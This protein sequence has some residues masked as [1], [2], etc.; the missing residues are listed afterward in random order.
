MVPFIIG[1]PNLSQSE[2]RVGDSLFSE[3]CHLEAEQAD[4]LEGIIHYYS[5]D[6]E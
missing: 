5:A 1:I 4:A 2:C 3:V 6:L